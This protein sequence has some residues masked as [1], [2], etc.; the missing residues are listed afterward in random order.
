ML[1]ANPQ[2]KN[3]SNLPQ[4]LNG[5][6]LMKTAIFLKQQWLKLCT[7]MLVLMFSVISH[8]AISDVSLTVVTDGEAPFDADDT[9][10]NDSSSNNGI[11]R[12][13]DNVTYRMSY[14]SSSVANTKFVFR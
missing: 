8:A 12:T 2:R 10:G 7:L 14:M 9:P 3:Q 11:V 6:K 4:D 5:K 1:Q 13:R